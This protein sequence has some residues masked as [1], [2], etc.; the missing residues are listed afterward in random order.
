M[1]KLSGRYCFEVDF[2][3]GLYCIPIELKT[4]FHKIL[5]NINEFR[6]MESEEEFDELNLFI[7]TFENY[8]L[9]NNFSKYSFTDLQ[10][11]EG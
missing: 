11:I 10:E 6:E 8:K 3:G 2:Y 5:Q 1:T 9:E 7:N 4:K